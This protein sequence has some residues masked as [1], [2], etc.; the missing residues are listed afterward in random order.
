VTTF[1]VFELD[2]GAGELRRQ[3][4]RVHL[5]AQPFKVLALLSSRPGSIVTREELRR[6]LWSEGTFVEFDRGLNFCIAEAR[7]ALGDDARSPRFIETIPKQGYRFIAE[8]RSPGARAPRRA[9]RWSWAA[10]IPFLVMQHPIGKPAHSRATANREALE[11]FERGIRNTHE[12]DNAERRRGIAALRMATRLDPRFAEAH[13]A[14]ADLYLRLA[15]DRELPM[16]AAI[17]EARSAAERALALEDVAESRQVLGNIRVIADWDLPGARRELA[18]A[19]ALEPAS[20]AAFVSYAR[21][22]SASGDDEAAI[23]AIDRAET[24][25]PNCDLILFDAGRIYARARRF[26]EAAKKFEGAITFGPPHNVPASEWKRFVLLRLLAISLSRQDWKAAH[27]HATAIVAESGA[28]EEVQK[29]FATRDPRDAVAAL[30]RRSLAMLT[31]P[32][33]RGRVAPTR[34]ATLQALLG[35]H[36]AALSSLERAANEKDPDL[37][38]ALG[39]SEFDELRAL[40]RFRAID[41]RVRGGASAQSD[42]RLR[43]SQPSADNERSAGGTHPPG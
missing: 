16:G 13:F 22:L 34:L 37:V 40:A 2:A 1:G 28:T 8:V 14:L 24:L 10:V 3:G 15:V 20:D 21:L 30:L 25:S 6:H 36:D 29:S 9:L 17:A 7:A 42:D 41:A 18:R 12:G 32:E 4:R 35:D 39:D 27:H 11:A 38:Y 19:V 33:Q 31:V 26:D 23:A 5:A 43:R